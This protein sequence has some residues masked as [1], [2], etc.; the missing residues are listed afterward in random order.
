MGTD[1]TDPDPEIMDSLKYLVITTAERIKMQSTPFD[2]KKQCW[3]PDHKEG[4]VPCE[5]QST[6]GEEVTV[7]TTKGETL[8]FKKDDLQQM[9]PP[10][11]HKCED[12]SDLTYLN[13]A[14][15][16]EN[17]RSRYINFLIYVRNK[18]KN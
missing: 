8:T 11:F 3:A 6:K 14:T 17:L 12:M 9:N 18:L 1:I 5:I 2:G 4:F 16:L 7:K 10:K 13:D 15:I